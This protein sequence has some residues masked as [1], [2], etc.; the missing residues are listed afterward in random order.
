[1][2]IKTEKVIGVVKP[3]QPLFESQNVEIP[4]PGMVDIK[5]QQQIEKVFS[6]KSK[7]F[8]FDCGIVMASLNSNVNEIKFGLSYHDENT[9]NF[10]EFI[11]SI[12]NFLIGVGMKL[13]DADKDRLRHHYKKYSIHKNTMI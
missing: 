8:K 2:N 6:V 7:Q 11:S 10:D 12:E 3:L 5:Q 13:T 1:M 9:S 4:V